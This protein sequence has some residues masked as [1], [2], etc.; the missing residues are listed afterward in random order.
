MIGALP[1]HLWF[2]FFSEK[3][4]QITSV[5][6]VLPGTLVQALVTAVVP[7]GLNVQLL[8]YFE[9]TIDLFHLPHGNAIANYQ[10]GQKVSPSIYHWLLIFTYTLRRSKREFCGTW[11]L[12]STERLRCHFFRMSLDSMYPV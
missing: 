1:D 8:G 7:G 4:S 11:L 2:S 3:L 6:S 9:G 10:L 12:L 5:T